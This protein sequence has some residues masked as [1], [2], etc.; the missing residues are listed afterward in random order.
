MPRPRHGFTLVEM[1]VVI[2]VM[3]VVFAMGGLIFGRAFESYHLA[4]MTTDAAAQGRLAL[5]RVAREL[6]QARGA[7]ANDLALDVAATSVRFNDLNGNG[8]CFYQAGTQLM[9][10]GDGPASACG[11][12]QAQPLADRL[13]TPGFALVAVTL[14]GVSTTTATGAYYLAVTI[15]VNNDGAI[16][17][18]RTAVF[19][20]AMAR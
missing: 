20:R 17:T 8:V 15:S 19:P 7:N 3:G 5:E 2:T 6:R 14:S 12:T 13:T 18:Y 9:R 1:I 11:T 4:R 16:E 10:S